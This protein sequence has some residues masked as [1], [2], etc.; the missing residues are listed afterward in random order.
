MD[1]S[2]VKKLEQPAELDE[3]S[4]VLLRAAELIEQ[5]GWVQG[6]AGEGHG[7][8]FCVDHALVS[9]VGELAPTCLWSADHPS[10]RR[11]YRAVGMGPSIWNDQPGRT[12]RDVLAKL[13]A[14]ALGG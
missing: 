6:S 10:Y 14:V 13:R 4:R 11:L 1:L 3:G 5:H 9:A 2:E 8:G 7:H 12:K